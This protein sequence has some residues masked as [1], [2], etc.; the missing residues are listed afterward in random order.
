MTE[1]W[2]HGKYVFGTSSQKEKKT[3]SE[4]KHTTIY[5][6]SL[7]ISIIVTRNGKIVWKHEQTGRSTHLC[8]EPSYT[9]SIL[10]YR[11]S[12]CKQNKEQDSE[13]CLYTH[14]FTVFKFLNANIR[15]SNGTITGCNFSK[16]LRL[17][18]YQTQWTA[19]L[20]KNFSLIFC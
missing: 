16:K 17:V 19:K 20:R 1:I 9:R 4:K 3:R 2:Q 15:W 5:L 6:G 14:I 10:L 13:D 7:I 8:W 11:A 12:K 18:L